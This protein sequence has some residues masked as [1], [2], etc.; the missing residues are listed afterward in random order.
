M[1]VVPPEFTNF[2]T[3]TAG[4]SPENRC[5]R[6]TPVSIF[7]KP[8]HQ[9]DE[10]GTPQSLFDHFNAIHHFDIDL[11]ASH[12]NHKCGRYFTKDK[13]ALTKRWYGRCWMNPPYSDLPAFTRKA[14]EEAQLG[15]TVVGLLPAWTDRQWYHDFCSDAETTFLRRRIKFDGPKYAK[16]TA[17]FPSMIV[18]WKPNS[19]PSVTHHAMRFLSPR[20]D[21]LA[22]KL[23]VA[24]QARRGAE[25]REFD[26]LG[27]IRELERK[28]GRTPHNENNPGIG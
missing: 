27:K 26:L 10:Y 24:E 6:K 12:R 5:I 3:H 11:A 15:A 4:S 18:V 1:R 23:F 19:G 20:T 22:G 8:K 2:V 9:S 25:D 16:H 21:D 13:S 14:H 28:I 7:S 17:T